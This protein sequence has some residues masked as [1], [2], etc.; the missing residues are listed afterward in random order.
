MT[1]HSVYWGSH[2]CHKPTGHAG[3]CRCS[4]GNYLQD[5]CYTYGDDIDTARTWQQRQTEKHT[6]KDAST[7]KG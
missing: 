6:A 2:G 1:K 4:C 3:A 5:D 7:A